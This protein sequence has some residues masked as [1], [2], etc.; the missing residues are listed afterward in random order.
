MSKKNYDEI[1]V[2][3]E[4]DENFFFYFSLS[5]R[6]MPLY[7]Y[8]EKIIDHDWKIKTEI[9]V[10]NNGAFLGFKLKF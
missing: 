4:C 8:H 1:F 7:C 10:K 9:S 5:R 3:S 2:A 6:N